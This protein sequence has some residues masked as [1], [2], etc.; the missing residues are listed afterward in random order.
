MKL[1]TKLLVSFLAVGVIPFAI[2]ALVALTNGSK[3]LSNQAFNQLYAIQNIKKGQIENYFKERL[4]DISVLSENPFVAEALYA[5]DK[6]FEAGGN[7]AAGKQYEAAEYRY[8]PWLVQYEKEYGYYDLFLIHEDGQVVYTVEKESD[9]GEN[10]M[11]GSLRS[12]N[13]AKC[14]KKAMGGQ[15][16]F[17]D[18]EPYAP[19]NNEPCAF[20]CAPVRRDGRIDGVTAL[21]IPL[22][23]VNAIMQERAGMGKTG[24]TYLVGPDKLMRS[25]SY[26]DP[27]NHSVVASFKNPSKGSVDTDASRKALA[28]QQ[29][30]EIIID[31]NGNPV[32]SA[33]APMRV[34]DVTWAVIAEIDEAE[35]FASVKALQWIISIVALIAIGG[36]IGI[37][38]LI[39]RSITK[40]INRVIDGLGKGAGQ[41]SSASEQ[42]SSSSQQLSEGASE[43][44]SSLEEVSSSLEEMAS[45]TKQNAD[46]ANQANTMA[47][48][49]SNSAGQS[50]ES[51]EKMT[52]AIEKIKAS[53]DETAKIIKTIDEIAMQTNLLAL[54]AAVEAARAGEAGR[55]FA[56]VAEEVRNLAQRSAEAAKNTSDLIEGAQR[57]VESGVSLSA[58][59]GKSLIQITET[60]QKVT[61][62]IAEVSAA[63]NEQSTGIEQVNSS[64]AQMDKV[65]QQNAANS[66]E[67]ASASEELSSQAQ[68][69]NVMVEELIAIVG[70]S[71]TSIGNYNRDQFSTSSE[72][73]T[74]PTTQIKAAQNIHSLLHHNT[75]GKTKGGIPSERRAMKRE[76]R[77][78]PEKQ[79]LV[80]AGSNEINPEQVIPLNDDEELNKF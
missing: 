32:L 66:E 23:A 6:G 41:V 3:S 49:A 26:L 54:N 76:L 8:G 67:S 62:L 31:Y 69:L 65:T 20:V 33:F 51:M 43:Q 13:L 80:S 56:V 37:A 21:Q 57:N 46:N 25:D 12:S 28:G 1:G 16:A 55:G 53:S 19:S 2:I 35:A 70:G 22:D 77:S 59:V 74:R 44:A 72:N 5:L 50:K 61:H 60:V 68:G 38:L 4:G 45:M 11:S 78:T 34:G 75:Q 18:F 52:V 27:T 30:N 17:V 36:I 71:T 14:F 42:L 47:T 29:G 63:S 79:M 24:E 40:P 7:R 39:T 48:E 64:V 73:L 10:L 58:E 15:V 9:L